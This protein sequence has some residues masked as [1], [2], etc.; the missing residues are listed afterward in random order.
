MDISKFLEIAEP[1]GVLGV[2]V[3]QRGRQAAEWLLE[4]ECRRNVYSAAKSYTSCAVGFA[5]QEGLVSL[6]EKLVDAFP[7]EL[8]DEI[9]GNL[10]KA[11]VRDLLTMCLGQEQGGL[12][13]AQRPVY[14]E[15]NWVKLSLGL[16]FVYEPGTQFVYNNVG[17]YLAGILVQRRAGCDLVSYLM[18][19]LF[20]PLGIGNRPTWETDPLGN[21]FGAGGLLLTLTELHKFGIFCLQ[22]GEWNGRQLLSKKWIEESARCQAVGEDYG[23]LFW[24]GEYNSFRADGKYSQLSIILPDQESVVTVVS[25]CRKSSELMRAIYDHVCAQL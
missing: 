5:V 16:P 20:E 9:S 25:E 3:T 6:G 13:G 11:T 1:L 17:P 2:K 23:Y 14:E 10:A 8:P 12:M 4:D 22:G 24:R 21:T 15:K 18:P 7:G 19:R